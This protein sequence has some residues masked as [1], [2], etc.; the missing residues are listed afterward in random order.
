MHVI[1]RSFCVSKPGKSFSDDAV[2]PERPTD[3]RAECERYALCDG[4]TTGWFAGYFARALARNW[5]RTRC[6]VDSPHVLGN[7]VKEWDRRAPRPG[8]NWLEERQRQIGAGATFVGLKLRADGRVIVDA[9]G[10]ACCFQVRGGRLIWTVPLAAPNLFT[11]RP[12]LLRTSLP[13]DRPQ[14]FATKWQGGDIVILA[15]DALAKWIIQSTS[16]AAQCP[17]EF[18][19]RLTRLHQLDR[20]TKAIHRLIASGAMDDDDAACLIARVYDDTPSPVRVHT[21]HDRPLGMEGRS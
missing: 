13:S 4:A 21:R 7:A 12:P 10:D 20:V 15:S 8:P 19:D 14:R 11:S 9:V 17:F 3:V 6:G 5:C 16:N 1:S 18:L 2:Y